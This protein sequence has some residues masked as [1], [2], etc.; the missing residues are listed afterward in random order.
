MVQYYLPLQLMPWLP[1]SPSNH[2][3]HA[4]LL[5]PQVLGAGVAGLA[6]IQAAKGLGAVVQA[7]DVR[8]AAREQVES[9]GGQFLAVNSSS[10]QVGCQRMCSQSQ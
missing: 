4:L 5:P 7:Y 10:I 2:D 1:F 6:A 8:A 9:M 3:H